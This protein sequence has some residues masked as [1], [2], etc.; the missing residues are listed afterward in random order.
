M[1]LETSDHVLQDLGGHTQP[2]QHRLGLLDAHSVRGLLERRV[3][4]TG[5]LA[6]SV[7]PLRFPHGAVDRDTKHWP[8]SREQLFVQ[9]QE[10]PG[11]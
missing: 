10:D 6:R 5:A 8:S 7:V 4:L 1:V 11:R 3:L 9:H 2:T